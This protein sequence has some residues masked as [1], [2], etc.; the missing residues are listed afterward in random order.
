MLPTSTRTAVIVALFAGPACAEAPGSSVVEAPVLP[1]AP[2]S[3]S[4]T[5]VDP[6]TAAT[7]ADASAPAPGGAIEAGAP[8]KF[9]ACSADADCVAVPRVG[10]CHNGWNEAVAA[11][12]KDAYAT[13]FVCPDAH[14]ICAMFIVRDARV[15]RCDPAAHL[16]TLVS[17][18]SPKT[19]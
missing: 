1:V 19:N 14:P 17:V 7:S 12:Q 16:C 5:Q 18:H 2:P 6:S 3:A 4:A 8:A 15:P 13:S 11:S 9:R 10:C